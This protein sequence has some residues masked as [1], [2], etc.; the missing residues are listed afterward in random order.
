M[1]QKQFRSSQIKQL[2]KNIF[3]F[4][5]KGRIILF[6][7][8]TFQQKYLEDASFAEIKKTAQE[9]ERKTPKMRFS[10]PQTKKF[11]VE[12]TLNCNLNCDYCLVFKNN[13]VQLN[14]SMNKLE[15]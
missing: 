14:N 3:T 13:L 5:Q 10:L 8:I 7:R 6:N 4:V 12:I 11:R 1:K 9:M 2:S 15:S